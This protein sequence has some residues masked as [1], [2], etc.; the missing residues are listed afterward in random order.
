AMNAY[1]VWHA[2]GTGVDKWGENHVVNEIFGYPYRGWCTDNGNFPWQDIHNNTPDLSPILPPGPGDGP[3]CDPGQFASFNE[4]Y[5]AHFH[6][7]AY[8]GSGS[9]PAQPS[10]PNIGFVSDI[11]AGSAFLYFSCHGGGTSIA[12]RDT[13]NGVAQDPSDMVPWGDDYWPSTDGRVYD[14]SGGGSYSQTDLDA[15]LNNVHG[16]MTA[17]N[18]CMMANGK[19]NEV[20]LEHGGSASFGSYT[21]VSFV[22]SGWWWNL[23]VHLIT[24]ENYTIG[25]AATYATARVAELYTPGANNGPGNVDDTLQYVVYGDP[26]VHFVQPD[27]TSP[28]PLAI[29]VNYGGHQPDKPPLSFIVTINPDEIPIGVTST[30]QVNVKDADTLL[31]L[32]ANVSISGWGVSDG[33]QTNAGGNASFVITPPYGENLTLTVEKEDYDTYE[34][35]ITVTGGLALSG[36]ITASVPSLGVQGVLAPSIEGMINGTSP[37]SS[38]TLAAKGCGIDMSVNTTTGS[39]SMMVTPASVGTVHAALLKGGY[40]VMPQDISVLVLHLGISYSPPSLVVNQEQTVNVTVNC[41]ESGTLIEGATVTISGCG[42]NETNVTDANGMTRL[43]VTP[44]VNGYATITVQRSGF[45]DEETSILVTKANMTVETIG[46]MQ[47]NQQLPVTVYVNNSFTGEPI[48]NATVSISGCG[49]GITNY[50][51]T[52][53]LADGEHSYFDVIVGDGATYLSGNLVWDGSADIDMKLYDPNGNLVDSSTS[54]TPGE[55]VEAT[56][57]EAGTWQIDVYSYSGSTPSFTL[58]ITIEY[59]TGV[60]GVTENGS[61]TLVIQPTSTGT[62]VVTAAKIGYNNGG[63]TINVV[64]GPTGNMEGIIIDSTTTAPLEN[65]TVEC[66][67]SSV[68]PQENDP[69]FATATNA[70]GHYLLSSMPAGEY[71]VC[72][73]KFGY[74]PHSGVAEI[75]ENDTTF[76]NITLLPAQT[77]VVQGNVTDS[78]TGALLWANITVYREDTGAEVT[79]VGAPTGHYTL[80]LIPYTY[81]FKV[82][83]AQHLTLQETLQITG[84]TVHDFE[85]MPALFLDTVESGE[86]GWTHSAASGPDL[87]HITERDSHS[88][89]HSWY[90]GYET[91]EYDDSMDDSLMTPLFNLTNYQSAT[92][93]F[94]HKYDFEGA[95]NPYDGSD[96]EISVDGGTWEQLFP[97]G[98]YD[99]YIYG[100]GNA[101]F[102]SGTAVYAHSSNGWKEAEFDLTDYAGSDNV[103]IRFRFGSDGSVHSYEGWYIDDIAIYGEIAAPLP[104]LT[105]AE[106][107]FSDN[108]PWAGDTI[109][110]NAT[111][112]NNGNKNASN[113][114]VRFTDVTLESELIIGNVT[115]DSL[116]Y[117]TQD[118]ASIPWQ[119]VGGYH[120]IKVE[121]D[122]DGEIEEFYENNNVLTKE[123]TVSSGNAP[124]TCEITAPPAYSAVNGTVTISG[125]ASDA[126]GTVQS[127]YVKIGEENWQ[128]ANGT[129]AWNLEWDTAGMANGFYDISAYSYDGEDISPMDSIVVTVDNC[130]GSYYIQWSHNYGSS[131]SDARYQGPQPIGDA[132]NDGLNELLIGG[133]DGELHVMKWNAGTSTYEEQA[134]LTEP[135]GSGDNPGGFAIGDVDNDGLNEIAVA[136]DYHFSAFEWNGAAYVQIGTTWVG[137][138][139]DNTYDCF[140][141]DFDDDG[142]NEV[143]LADDPYSG[144]PEITVLSWSNSKGDFVEKAYWDYPGTATTPMAWVVDV[145]NDGSN[146]IIC[147]PG[148]DLVVL[149]WNGASF[150][151]TTVDTFSYE[152]YACVCGDAN[153]NG[154]PEIAVGLHSPDGYIYEWN[155]ALYENIWS[156][157]WPGEEAV[158]EAV[159]IGDT[160]DDGYAEVGFGTD[161]VHLVQWNG[162]TYVEEA[163]LPTAGMLAPLAIGDCDNDGKNEINAGNV[164]DAPYMEWVFKYRLDNPPTCNI[165]YPVNGTTV[166]GTVNL[167][168]NAFDADN[169]SLNIFV[170]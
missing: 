169:D 23:F 20:L 71:T 134:L 127:V 101:A 11:N 48:D 13:D 39:A 116:A 128:V 57:P 45:A 46:E 155:G 143:V 81:I 88:S 150:T 56:N 168:G 86:N 82:E 33:G 117:G 139:T 87:W 115:I 89:S 59:G 152:T 103:R 53:S 123:I 95:T 30:V 64:T 52:G 72:A 132:D 118:I 92:L 149:D 90:C 98:W 31:P 129:T 29:N 163:T 26:N 34:G 44:L 120:I 9:H 140:I 80:N 138:G 113:V 136:W 65:V 78:N 19:M 107:S 70:S 100:S 114:T 145:D 97:V 85:L 8:A 135:G 69:A 2:V 159:A 68:N 146:E 24:H 75:Y 137:D 147:V 161:L 122:P 105:I 112:A 166:S 5:E 3:D 164:D 131:I 27:W 41:T 142:N 63:T 15:D 84:N 125:T 6:S 50:V 37:T 35:I 58:N 60:S 91:G 110:I 61:V 16:S 51:E 165:T 76:Y 106:I 158:I 96:V 133:R 162:T 22:G 153:G 14:G 157:T 54:T 73:W 94:W 12:V 151:A 99:D 32:I 36:T 83:A 4:F 10:V 111:V 7:G 167:T 43:T 124:P 28:E 156:A 79:S 49:I 38:F 66:Y 47:V 170:R 74:E 109:F 126:D 42:M 40:R 102:P 17:Y 93:T 62:M 55:F 141:G 130:A 25:E 144:N 119:A 77:Y 160:D 121:A 108:E 148:Y 67:N 1:E 104:D 154:I 21:S 18:A